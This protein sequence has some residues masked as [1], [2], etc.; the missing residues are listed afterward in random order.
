MESRVNASNPYSYIFQ[1]CQDDPKFLRKLLSRN[2]PDFFPYAIDYALENPAFL[3]RILKLAS[4]STKIRSKILIY[5]DSHQE[6]K[7]N[8]LECARKCRVQWVSKHLQ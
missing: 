1:V 6:V 3:R 5:A 8:I 2:S 7:S 4:D